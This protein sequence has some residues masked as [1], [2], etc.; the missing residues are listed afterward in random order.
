MIEAESGANMLRSYVP[1]SGSKPAALT[2]DAHLPDCI[3]RK[4][5][6][7][8]GSFTASQNPAR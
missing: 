1:I 2:R 3:W 7:T 4:L 8:I 6:V 5:Y